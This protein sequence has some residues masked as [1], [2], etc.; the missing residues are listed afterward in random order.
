MEHFFQALA[1]VLLSV[2]LVLILRSC[3]KGIGELLS[4]LVCGM[5]IMIALRY[6]QPLIDFI[7][8]VQNLV[9]L[10]GQMLKILLK[11]VGISIT[12][13]IAELICQDSGNGAMGKSLQILATAVIACLSIPML[14]TLMELIEGVLSNV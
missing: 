10:D 6:I 7:D 1:A 13:E 2:I 4:I 12:A 14:T 8:S 3:D 5:V 11:S 9:S